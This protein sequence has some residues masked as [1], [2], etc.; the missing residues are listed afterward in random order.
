[1]FRFNQ[2]NTSYKTFPSLSQ[3]LLEEIQ[4]T[5]VIIKYSD[6]QALCILNSIG[7]EFTVHASFARGDSITCHFS[8]RGTHEIWLSEVESGAIVSH[9]LC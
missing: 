4:R 6:R 8:P 5:S 3:E 2:L 7:R 9:F 1:M